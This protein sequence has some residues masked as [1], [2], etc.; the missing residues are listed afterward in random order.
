MK[1]LK[2]M[3]VCDSDFLA[4]DKPVKE[5]RYQFPFSC[6]VVWSALEDGEAWGQWLD[7]IDTVEW[8]S[9]KPF[10]VGTTRTVRGG[11]NVIEEVFFTWKQ[12]EEMAFYFDK[13][14]LPLK[15]FAESYKLVPNA[16]GCELI[17]RFRA[18]ANFILRFLAQAALGNAG[19]KGFPLLEKIISQNPGKYGG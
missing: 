11:K 13:S 19:K 17:W 6:E 12:N 9:P 1:P 5:L 8:T 10:A 15:A 18:E 7:G 4:S 3:I 16:Q 2:Q 14:N